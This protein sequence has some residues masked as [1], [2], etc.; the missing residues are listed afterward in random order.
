ME[1][2]YLARDRFRR[3]RLSA[4]LVGAGRTLTERWTSWCEATGGRVEAVARR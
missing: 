4:V 1:R 2:D 3:V